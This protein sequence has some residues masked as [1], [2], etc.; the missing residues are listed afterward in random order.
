MS[1]LHESVSRRR[2]AEPAGL[3]CVV[4]GAPQPGLLVTLWSGASW[5]LPWSYLVNARF[6]NPPGQLELSFT[7]HIVLAEGDNLGGVLDDLAGFRLGCLRDLPDN[8]RAQLAP[9][10]PFIRRLL[11]RPASRSENPALDSEKSASYTEKPS[12]ATETR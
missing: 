9:D 1:S 6:I 8:Y 12:A 4:V 7:S 10:V 2:A 5:V 11:V 3:S